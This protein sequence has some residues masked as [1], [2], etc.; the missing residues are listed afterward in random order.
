[1]D[2][3]S[4]RTRRCTYFVQKNTFLVLL[5]RSTGLKPPELVSPK[6]ST[7]LDSNL[8]RCHGMRLFL[9]GHC[10][11][12][13]KHNKDWLRVLNDNGV[14]AGILNHISLTQ[15]EVTVVWD[16]GAT[17]V[18]GDTQWHKL[19]VL[20]CAAAGRPMFMLRMRHQVSS[21][22]LVCSF[23]VVKLE[24]LGGGGTSV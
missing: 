10:D 21:P 7:A 17:V 3:Y 6:M 11:H 16:C 24:E 14:E 8:Q 9:D 1:M 19:R 2:I 5:F 22:V 23:A 15:A 18:Y 20:D 4:Q 13:K 12:Q